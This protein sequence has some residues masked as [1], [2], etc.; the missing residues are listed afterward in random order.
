MKDRK[1]PGPDDW[2]SGK[3]E[4]WSSSASSGSVQV[5]AWKVGEVFM[6]KVG[7]LV[8]SNNS[9]LPL[10]VWR[11]RRVDSSVEI[12]DGISSEPK[13]R[14]KDDENRFLSR[15]LRSG[16][17][18]PR[19]G[20]KIAHSEPTIRDPRLGVLPTRLGVLPHVEFRKQP[21]LGVSNTRLGVPSSK[22]HGAISFQRLSVQ[23]VTPSVPCSA[24]L[25]SKQRPSI[26]I[27]GA[28]KHPTKPTLRRHT[29]MP[30]RWHQGLQQ[31][32]SHTQRQTSTPRHGSCSMTQQP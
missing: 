5:R 14:R 1:R 7:R 13:L 15:H 10:C 21:R 25:G 12:E 17:S 3:Y 18:S 9:S 27:N 16:A 26:A 23:P 32:S 24:S 2:S 11:T 6:K 4:R 19:P 31:V 8:F 30:K 22:S 29:H 20:A 28:I